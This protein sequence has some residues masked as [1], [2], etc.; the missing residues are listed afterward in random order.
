ML[1]K[2]SKLG[3]LLQTN[4]FLCSKPIFTNAC[5]LLRG[6]RQ[7]WKENQRVK[8]WKEISLC[9]HGYVFPCFTTTNITA[10]RQNEESQTA[11][12][13]YF[14]VWL[15]AV[16]WPSLWSW[17]GVPVA[18]VLMLQPATAKLRRWLSSAQWLCHFF[19][20]PLCWRPHPTEEAGK[21]Q[22]CSDGR[23]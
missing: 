17:A 4:V 21:H 22:H 12:S 19:V 20:L 2:E 15:P 13:I 16:Q 10:K 11:F 14:Q 8:F 23:S 18:T 6:G 3:G 1:A 7:E 9:L 5:S